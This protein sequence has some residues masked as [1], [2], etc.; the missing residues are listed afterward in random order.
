MQSFHV[1]HALATLALSLAPAAASAAAST[2]DTARDMARSTAGH[3]GASPAAPPAKECASVPVEIAAG[4]EVVDLTLNRCATEASAAAVAELSILARPPSVA[5]PTESIDAL[6]K[7]AG[8]LAPG[9]RRL[10]GRLVDRLRQ[11]IDHFA[12]DHKTTRVDIVS[13][14]RPRGSGSLH[15]AGRALDFRIEGV[16]NEALVSFCETLPDTGCGYY[17]NGVFVHIDV[18]ERGTGRVS[19]VDENENAS[20]PREAARAGAPAAPS[21]P[22]TEQGAP[23]ALARS[24][25]PVLGLSLA[26]PVT[27]EPA[28]A[29]LPPLPKATASVSARSSAVE[30]ESRPR[31]HRRHHERR[32]THEI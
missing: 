1:V 23:P 11:V 9:V 20:A 13:G 14:F 4:R 32:R 8:E 19:W 22:A 21:A 30:N 6:A 24:P 27:P 16:Q 29:E 31:H 12:T 5:R 17:P 7:K 28:T 10:D 25:Q 15:S 26:V 2:H 18:R 3:A